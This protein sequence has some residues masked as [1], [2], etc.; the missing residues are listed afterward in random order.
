MTSRPYHLC[1]VDSMRSYGGAE[2][3]FLDTAR[4]LRKRGLLV[5]IITQPD[6]VWLPRI[7]SAG[8]TCGAIPL[9]C[10]AAPWT[11]IKLARWFAGHGVTAIVA[12][13]TKDL[14]ACAVAGR[15]AAVPVI[16]GARESDFPLKDKYYYRWYFQRL[17]TG[18]LVNSL[19]T[20]RTVLSSAP[21]LD[22][23]RVHTLYKG[24]DSRRFFPAA[25]PPESPII[26][27]A[28]QLIVR[29]G[30]R[31]LMTAW[32]QL[33]NRCRQGGQDRPRLRV[34]GEGPLAAEMASWR[35]GLAH[36]DRVELL[37]FQE[38]MPRFFQ[39]LS[40]LVMP[41]HAEGFGLAAAEASA[42]G[43]PVI[44]SRASSLPEII[45]DGLT[46][47]LHP[48]GQPAA[49]AAAMTELC[50]DP[51]LCQDMGR[52]GRR[53]IQTRFGMETCLDRL[54]ALTRTQD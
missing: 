45:A 21:W 32:T 24:I 34:A 16:L 28:G 53:M 14:K 18:L 38:D 4:R 13:R 42:C 36:P 40:M 43:L 25:H 50:L 3:W 23:D 2:V 30:L 20:R 11:W 15:L 39:G 46:G 27:F 8:L 52:A 48:P 37:G 9:R 29:K 12:N 54:V 47:I 22:P 51:A 17:A 19:A 49:L 26:G 6:A 44:A 33:D 1:L 35:R 31:D 10:D 7:R 41:S 5:S